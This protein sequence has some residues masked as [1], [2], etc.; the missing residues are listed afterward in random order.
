MSAGLHARLLRL[1]RR[2]AEVVALGAEV[3]ALLAEV[4]R[5]DPPAYERLL[6]EL[7]PIIRPPERIR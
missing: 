1:E 4:E 5:D 3:L 7:L 2:R 6:A